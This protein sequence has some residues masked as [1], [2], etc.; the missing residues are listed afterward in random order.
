LN[1]F[2]IFEK[3]LSL[4]IQ[5]TLIGL[6]GFWGLSR[7]LIRECCLLTLSKLVIE[8]TFPCYIFTHIIKNT[9]IENI[10]DLIWLPI[11][12]VAILALGYF[13]ASIY[14]AI[15]KKVKE[16]GEFKLL[17]TFQNAVYIPLPIISVLFPEP[18]RSKIFLYLF[19]FNIPFSALLFSVSPH[20]LKRKSNLTFTWRSILN[21]PVIAVL[22]SL[23]I[24][25]TGLNRFM[26][27]TLL[28]SMEMLGKITVPLVMIVTGGII[29]I[30]SRAEVP[31]CK[32]TITKISILKLIVIPVIV[33]AVV[34]LLPIPHEIAVLLVLEA[35]VPSSATLPLIARNEEADYKLIGT[36]VF[37]SYIASIFSVPFFLGLY[38]LLK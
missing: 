11:S 13:V 30:N 2:L 6:V 17:I 10:Q 38:Y 1:P 9:S 35:C 37:Y 36:T 12:C 34:I 32:L 22:V 5:I 28:T 16:T 26:P 29:F 23:I 18:E 3:T 19:T 8:I 25:F 7:G 27:E 24:V 4:M 21:N 14:L 20:V 15:D 33:I 31:A